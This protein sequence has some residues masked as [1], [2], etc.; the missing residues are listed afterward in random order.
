MSLCQNSYGKWPLDIASIPRKKCGSFHRY[1]N[2]HQRV[3]LYNGMFFMGFNPLTCFRMEKSIDGLRIHW[4]FH[5]PMRWIS[6]YHWISMIYSNE[7]SIEYPIFSM[8][9][10][11]ISY[12]SP[13]SLWSIDWFK[14]NITGKFG[15]SLFEIM[16]K[17][18]WFPVFRFSLQLIHW[19]ISINPSINNKLCMYIDI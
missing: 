15:K 10:P 6:E 9:F 7:L 8:R 18:G 4:S 16:G 19:S 14:G 2:V 12:P 5:P 3:I 17:S 13:I 11:Y 1:V